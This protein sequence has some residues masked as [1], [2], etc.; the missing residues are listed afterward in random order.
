MDNTSRGAWQK[1]FGHCTY[2]NLRG[3]RL[4]TLFFTLRLQLVR[5]LSVK[6]VLGPELILAQIGPRV[7]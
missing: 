7:S 4:H 3:A 2:G 5:A 6:R 1:Q